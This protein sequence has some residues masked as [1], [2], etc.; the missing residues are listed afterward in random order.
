MRTYEGAVNSYRRDL[1]VFTVREGGVEHC[2]FDNIVAGMD[3]LAD[4]VADVLDA[5]PA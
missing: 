3:V 5:S 1:K 4:W 2:Q